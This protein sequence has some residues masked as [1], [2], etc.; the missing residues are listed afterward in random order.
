MFEEIRHELEIGN[1]AGV[2]ELVVKLLEESVLPKRILEEGLVSGM[3][4]IGAKFRKNEVFIPEVMIAAK[5][6]H[7]GLDVLNPHLAKSGVKPAGRILIGTVKGDLH[8]I[9]KN[10]VGMMFRGAGFEVVDCGIDVSPKS[11]VEAL[12]KEA[13]DIVAMSSLLTTSMPFMDETLKLLKSE[14]LD[15][16]VRTM[17][18][19][20][21]VT[22]DFAERIGASGYA[23]DASQAVDKARE[24]L[25]IVRV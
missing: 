20:A 17:V 16:K 10:I 22:Q 12:E 21:P 8:D 5:A 6:M 3:D 23:S 11:F 4:L 9:G 14:G 19:G 24:L 18:G 1:A 2:K 7:A 15:L 13:F 25:G